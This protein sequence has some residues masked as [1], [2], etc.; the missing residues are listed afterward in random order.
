MGKGEGG[1]KATLLIQWSEDQKGRIPVQ[2]GAVQKGY[3]PANFFVA[4]SADVWVNTKSGKYWKP[5]SRY[6]ADVCQKTKRSRM[7]ICQ[8]PGL[9]ND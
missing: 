1:S 4:N 9:E 5:G 8:R 2:E 7:G 3:Q 6:R